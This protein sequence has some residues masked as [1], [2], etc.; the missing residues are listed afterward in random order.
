MKT[1]QFFLTFQPRLKAH[2]FQP[3]AD[4]TADSLLVL[5]ENGAALGVGPQ[6]KRLLQLIEKG[7]L[8]KDL[9]KILVSERFAT[10]NQLK[11]LL[12]DLDRYGFLEESPW[13][14]KQ[15]V[16]DWG[17][18]GINTFTCSPLSMPW[19]FGRLASRIGGVLLSPYYMG[20]ILGFFVFCLWWGH[21]VFETIHPFILHESAATALLVV[22]LFVLGGCFAGLLAMATILRHI[23]PSAVR[24]L[25]DYRYGIPIFRLDGR[26][27]RLLPWPKALRAALS[28]VVTL[29]FYSGITLLLTN[30]RQ[31][32]EQEWLFHLTLALW[33]A[34]FL[35]VTP[36]ISSILT[37][38][39]MFRLRGDCSTWTLT[40]AI[41]NAFC[42]KSETRVLG[43]AYQR[44]FLG[45]SLLYI[46][47]T[48]GLLF[49]LGYSFH[50]DAG[51]LLQLFF[52]ED[53]PII[54]TILLLICSLAGAA[55]A[56]TFVTFLVWLYREIERQI[57]FRF[58]PQTD[59][60]LVA[61]F[62]AIGLLLTVSSIR[63]DVRE[64]A[65]SFCYAMVVW[66]LIACVGSVA[67]WKKEG[68]GQEPFLLLCAGFMGLVP[69]L[70]GLDWLRLRPGGG[71]GEAPFFFT[72][73][74]EPGTYLG[75]VE[76]MGWFAL[77]VYSLSLLTLL[78]Y[79][80]RPSRG[81]KPSWVASGVFLAAGGGV[82][83]LA[84]FFSPSS[85]GMMES[86]GRVLV[87]GLL[88]LFT[89]FFAFWGFCHNYS[90]PLM[91]YGL[92]TIAS[93]SICA[94]DWRAYGVDEFFMAVGALLV[95]CSLILRR[96]GAAKTALG[97]RRARP[98]LQTEPWALEEIGHELVR[99]SE[100]LYGM[101]PRLPVPAD[102][103]EAAARHFFYE[104][105]RLTGPNAMRNLIRRVALFSPWH[106]TR[107]LCGLVPPV[108][109]IP[110]LSDWTGTRIQLWLKKVPSFYYAREE[111]PSLTPKIR[112]AVFQAGETL[113]RQGEKE[114]YLYILLDGTL[115]AHKD[116]GFGYTVAAVFE[117][118]DFV[119]E[120]GF[121]SGAR[122]TA[123]I[124][125]LQPSLVMAIHRE[126]I[127]AGTP[128]TWDAM[129]QAET[130]D[131]WLQT[132]NNTQIFREYS[133]SLSARV[134]L[135]GRLLQ[136]EADESL[137][138]DAQT[139]A[140]T[141]TV[142]LTGKSIILREGEVKQ[143]EEG[144]LIGFREC[145]DETPM[146]GVI[147]AE[148]V[149]RFLLID[150]EFFL[151]SLIEVLTPK[152]VLEYTEE[153]G[154]FQPIHS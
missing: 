130:G 105:T 53:N 101:R 13:P 95:F 70:H 67:T 152:P 133:A 9:L 57:K 34:G 118:G 135:E 138:L 104:F 109:E 65:Y 69:V 88:G 83:W 100:E 42:R 103:T 112:L 129:K 59:F 7:Y 17:Y 1:S 148:T 63:V 26:R 37:R 92:L 137:R 143:L 116:H 51:R 127:D 117:P 50:W 11:K 150:R 52:Q 154:M 81:P 91:T 25:V 82:F 22:F 140:N 98:P 38:E 5:D 113:A 47:L 56:T 75:A 110:R 45:W 79:H 120:I 36:W 132:L 33:L 119:G 99:A 115:A 20:F 89:L 29:F 6:E 15:E 60:S 68:R 84:W 21:A 86:A 12:W 49:A 4:G 3:A 39:V 73:P 61:V 8:I 85:S 48:G 76:L 72:L 27:L 77:L 19:L 87:L 44:L 142:F 125:A 30:Q 107:T 54:L 66:G 43:A 80:L 55:M 78:L 131:Y 14:G 136:L 121:L 145:L 122:R 46:V 97:L 139:A 147:R 124:R 58:L 62:F 10:L 93:G 134:C 151:D 23:H 146:Q 141:V 18:W 2:S 114:G 153:I 74:F 35:L 111:F 40:T 108:V 128:K 32:A 126:D 106:A 94:A 31:G 16:A 24:C 28:P 90:T 71:M 144:M 149:S 123:S 102:M 64:P 96:T 41:K